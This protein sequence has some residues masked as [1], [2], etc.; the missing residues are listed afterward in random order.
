MSLSYEDFAAGI[1]Q[2]AGNYETVMLWSDAPPPSR[3]AVTAKDVFRSAHAT[4]LYNLWYYGD[5]NDILMLYSIVKATKTL[6]ATELAIVSLVSFMEDR[7]SITGPLDVTIRGRAKVYDNAIFAS[8]MYSSDPKKEKNLVI[9]VFWGALASL[10]NSALKK[11]YM[12]LGD[13]TPI[14]SK[15]ADDL[16]LDPPPAIGNDVPY[17]AKKAGHLFKFMPQMRAVPRPYFYR[18]LDLEPGRLYAV[19]SPGDGI[20]ARIEAIVGS[21]NAFDTALRVR[22][23]GAYLDASEQGIEVGEHVFELQGIPGAA[24]ASN[25]LT[26]NSTSLLLPSNRTLVTSTGWS[27]VKFVLGRLPHRQSVGELYISRTNPGFGSDS[28][29]RSRQSNIPQIPMLPGNSVAGYIKNGVPIAATLSSADVY[30]WPGTGSLVPLLL[31]NGFITP[32]VTIRFHVEAVDA[33]YEYFAWPEIDPQIWPERQNPLLPR[34]NMYKYVSLEDAN[35]QASTRWSARLIAWYINTR[36]KRPGQRMGAATPMEAWLAFKPNLPRLPSAE[37]RPRQVWRAHKNRKYAPNG[38]PSKFGTEVGKE[39]AVWVG[40]N[41]QLSEGLALALEAWRK[42]PANGD[43]VQKIATFLPSRTRE[44]LTVH[45]WETNAYN[46]LVNV[47]SGSFFTRIPVLVEESPAHTSIEVVTLPPFTGLGVTM[48]RVILPVP[49]IRNKGPKSM[50]QFTGSRPV[51]PMPVNAM[52]SQFMAIKAFSENADP[53][54]STEEDDAFKAFQ[55]VWE[56]VAPRQPL[57]AQFVRYSKMAVAMAMDRNEILAKDWK[58]SIEEG[59]FL[60][61]AYTKTNVPDTSIQQWVQYENS[62][63]LQAIRDELV[64]MIEDKLLEAK[65]LLLVLQG[66][67]G[68][69]QAKRSLVPSDKK[70]RI[71]QLDSSK[72]G[73]TKVNDG[74]SASLSDAVIEL[75]KAI[76]PVRE[77]QQYLDDLFDTEIQELEQSIKNLETMPLITVDLSMAQKLLDNVED[78]LQTV[79]NAN[80]GSKYM[81]DTTESIDDFIETMTEF[82]PKVPPHAE[83]Y[84]EFA[85]GFQE[86]LLPFWENPNY[87]TISSPIYDKDELAQAKKIAEAEKRKKDLEDEAEKAK[88]LKAT[89]KAQKDNVRKSAADEVKNAKRKEGEA[90]V[91]VQAAEKL[92][93]V[94]KAVTPL[95]R[96][97]VAQAEAEVAK[98]QALLAELRVQTQNAEFDLQ[99][100]DARIA[101][102]KAAILSETQARAQEFK[103][104]KIQAERATQELQKKEAERQ[105]KAQVAKAQ[106][107]TA[108]NQRKIDEDA[109]KAKTAALQAEVDKITREREK[110]RRDDDLRRTKATKAA[111]EEQRKKAEAEQKRMEEEDAKAAAQLAKEQQKAEKAARLRILQA[112]KEEEEETEIA[113]LDM[114]KKTAENAMIQFNNLEKEA[115]NM[116][117]KLYAARKR[118]RDAGKEKDKQNTV[119]QRQNS[120]LQAMVT[121]FNRKQLDAKAR[122]R[123]LEAELSDHREQV[124]LL[125]Q[126]VTAAIKN[127]GTPPEAAIDSY[128]RALEKEKEL[129][130]ELSQHKA[131][132]EGELQALQ[133]EIDEFRRVV[134]EAQEKLDAATA[135]VIV[136]TDNANEAN[137]AFVG[138]IEKLNK[139]QETLDE[140]NNAKIAKDKDY[141]KK[142]IE[143]FEAEKKNRMKA[144]DK[145][146]SAAYLEAKEEEKAAIEE[147][148]RQYEATLASIDSDYQKAEATAL[149]AFKRAQKAAQEVRD[150]TLQQIQKAVD[151]AEAKVKE[152]RAQLTQA[153]LDVQ[154]IEAEY[155][156]AGQ[157]AQDANDA[158]QLLEPG[159]IQANKDA[160]DAAAILAAQRKKDDDALKLL[161]KA[162]DTAY[163]AATYKARRGPNKGKIVFRSGSSNQTV[164]DAFKTAEAEYTAKKSELDQRWEVEEEKVKALQEAAVKARQKADAAQLRNDEAVENLNALATQKRIAV[165]E[166]DDLPTLLK[167]AEDELGTAQREAP[168]QIIKADSDLNDTVVS[169]EQARDAAIGAAVAMKESNID[170][171]KDVLKAAKTAAKKATETAIQKAD[172]TAKA[173]VKKITDETNTKIEAATKKTEDEIVAVET[174]IK[175]Q[176]D[177]TGEWQTRI[178]KAAKEYQRLAKEIVTKE[179]ELKVARE[180]AEQ[181]ETTA[182]DARD[183]LAVKE[184]ELKTAADE[185]AATVKAK[186]EE[187]GELVKRAVEKDQQYE[188]QILALQEKID[189]IMKP[190]KEALDKATEDQAALKESIDK[191]QTLVDAKGK[192]LKGAD[193]RVTDANEELTAANAKVA[194]E[195]GLDPLLQKTTTAVAEQQA[196][197]IK[198]AEATAAQAPIKT[199]YDEAGVELTRLLKLLSAANQLVVDKTTIYNDELAKLKSET[200]II[201]RL[202]KEKQDALAVD[203]TRA[204]VAQSAEV[205]RAKGAKDAIDDLNTEIARLGGE[206]DKKEQDANDAD[207]KV[208]QL[209]DDLK[210]LKARQDF[211]G[212]IARLIDG[213]VQTAATAFQYNIAAFSLDDDDNWED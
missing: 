50:Q 14:T 176:K 186:A 167:D 117:D 30:K 143:A 43:L 114:T 88:Q 20:N 74:T 123:K 146:K 57:P 61:I 129:E 7:L 78:L 86:P 93:V 175:V 1:R 29:T 38:M 134:Q 82:L 5:S 69:W 98:A 46:A 212:K 52:I 41:S 190:F 178:E 158:Y 177:A 77:D 194:T 39:G 70:T 16:L 9:R 104:A 138:A 65:L 54:P 102:E 200:D 163:N 109:L 28:L 32:P 60:A 10:S 210:D 22:L 157:E 110:Q 164:L 211:Q 172:D 3:K 133:K 56:L 181:L 108:E 135:F 26:E 95:D 187:E 24:V 13:D 121:H 53:N 72:V 23:P 48:P 45:S 136:E 155:I 202:G 208:A 147:A 195:K 160:S 162:R 97:Q 174:A 150:A 36:E 168:V 122:M 189:T 6:A 188:D 89:K 81:L 139:A 140:A 62:L 125:N 66:N 35:R 92:V 94:A 151:D 166:R 180:E 37:D 51:T 2:L 113:A 105:Q 152:L 173:E 63:M 192:E 58:W 141:L 142:T 185:E 198:V 182:R 179:E 131:S 171:A 19:V 76:E 144:I 100:I 115:Q 128:T 15:L 85:Q 34:T 170:M 149:D 111:A 159:A 49:E 67:I 130:K 206:K 209:E 153:E 205:S 207:A 213:R 31:S 203:A 91:A 106:A 197:A 96:M 137:R 44:A 87:G 107:I 112:Q 21:T 42:E 184:G 40:P 18:L 12:L 68:R 99:Q 75:N 183:T 73:D 59:Y 25:G 124:A 47:T 116:E 103:Q 161:E 127:T 90:L 118:V 145:E 55:R 119:F 33:D 11:Q 64:P 17:A 132:E 156:A 27:T 126:E 196:A 80:I 154:K 79:A 84:I 169:S 193:K 191:A 199:V 4:A 204:A 8:R 101:K 120:E 71:K 165:Q 148:N 201:T 83:G